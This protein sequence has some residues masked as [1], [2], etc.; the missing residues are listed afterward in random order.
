MLTIKS[1]HQ[2]TEITDLVWNVLEHCQCLLTVCFPVTVLEHCQCLLTV[3]F[4]VTVLEHCQCLLTVCFPVT[5]LEHCQCLLTVCVPVTV[6]Q[7]CQCLLT[8]CFPVTVLEHCQCLLT[9]CFPVTVLWPDKQP[10]C[11]TKRHT[12]EDAARIY[13]GSFLILPTPSEPVKQVEH[14]STDTHGDT[15]SY[16]TMN[17]TPLPHI[18]RLE[19]RPV[20]RGTESMQ[21]STF[22]P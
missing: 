10:K 13:P 18:C 11:L 16:A 9:V 4:P 7:H 14:P 12:N 20:H 17:K 19:S 8:V 21:P 2:H 6:L 3:C 5:V 1:L 22:S 15:A